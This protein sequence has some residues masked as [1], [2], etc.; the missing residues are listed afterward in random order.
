MKAGCVRAMGGMLASLPWRK[1]I[2]LSVVGLEQSGI[3]ALGSFSF[4]EGSSREPRQSSGS[5]AS[6]MPRWKAFSSAASLAGGGAVV[7][8]PKSATGRRG[9]ARARM[10]S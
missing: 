10:S 1:W 6:L 4:H 9:G 8:R 7:S 5:Q 2:E 3:E